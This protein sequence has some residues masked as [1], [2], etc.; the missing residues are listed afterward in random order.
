MLTSPLAFKI[1]K[2][3]CMNKLGT[4]LIGWL[5]FAVLPGCLNCLAMA[6]CAGRH[7]VS[8]VDE[9]GNPISVFEATFITEMGEE[10]I[11]SCPDEEE[12]RCSGEGVV[13]VYF[14]GEL[15]I[16]REDGTSETVVLQAG[17]AET[18]GCP[19]MVDKVAVL[20]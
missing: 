12:S 5:C 4:V 8:V 6:D 20:P 13:E 2:D 18:C 16:T 7:S 17:A 15:T 9:N 3:V 19:K 1:L 14:D 10:N 11:F